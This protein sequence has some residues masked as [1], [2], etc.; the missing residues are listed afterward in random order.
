MKMNMDSAY[1]KAG[2]MNGEDRESWLL[3][4]LNS[5]RE[6]STVKDL[7]KK[8]DVRGWNLLHFAA[9]LG[10]AKSVEALLSEGAHVDATDRDGWSASML[11]AQNGR[12]SCLAALLKGGADPYIRLNGRSTLASLAIEND[13][14]DC[15]EL[16]LSFEVDPNEHTGR[17]AERLAMVACKH[18]NAQCLA[19]VIKAGAELDKKNKRGVTALMMAAQRGSLECVDMLLSAGARANEQDQEGKTAL[20]YA[21]DLPNKASS[22]HIVSLLEKASLDGVSL[23]SSAKARPS[24]RV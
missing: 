7:I 24:L 20:S 8:S 6:S 19:I 18:G 13:N 3:G 21:L 4:L 23:N 16:L 1:L 11:A 12:T 9:A 2:N 17:D 14:I 22:A 15:V 10:N 5:A